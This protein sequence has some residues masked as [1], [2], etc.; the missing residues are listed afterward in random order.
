M[1][2][3]TRSCLKLIRTETPKL[4]RPA[5]FEKMSYEPHTY[6]YVHMDIPIQR[7]ISHIIDR[8][9][10]HTIYRPPV[11]TL[12]PAAGVVEPVQYKNQ[13]IMHI[14]IAK[15]NAKQQANMRNIL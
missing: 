10:Y 3:L 12:S 7:T 6:R 15:Q 5:N 11:C 4:S 13:P 8:G 14:P 2:M 9:I 1:K